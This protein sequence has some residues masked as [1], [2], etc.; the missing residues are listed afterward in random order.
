MR[1]PFCVMDKKLTFATPRV[2]IN[3]R[4]G[5]YRLKS[6]N[7]K[8]GRGAWCMCGQQASHDAIIDGG[9]G[10]G[11]MMTRV[12]DDTAAPHGGRDAT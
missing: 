6:R 1:T 9:G 2:L 10:G 11:G 4:I 7:P 12:G 8:K 5:V 3:F